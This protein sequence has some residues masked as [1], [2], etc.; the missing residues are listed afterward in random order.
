MVLNRKELRILAPLLL[1]A[2]IG[3]ALWA[4]RRAL[5]RKSDRFT[6]RHGRSFIGQITSS[7]DLVVTIVDASDLLTDCQTLEVSGT[8]TATVENIGDAAT[9]SGFTVLF[10]ED[11][12][13]NGTYEAGADLFL[14]GD[15]IAGSLDSGDETTASVLVD[16]TITF[17]GNLIYAFADSDGDV[18]EGDEANNINHSGAGCEF[19]PPPGGFDPVLEWAW[20]SSEVF[21]DW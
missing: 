2:L 17:A 1:I 18:G 20:D 21:S 11:S 13:D 9:G 15:V 14:G 3:S 12:N 8:V 6:N 4:D 10:F 5:N 7:P 16:Y 19:E